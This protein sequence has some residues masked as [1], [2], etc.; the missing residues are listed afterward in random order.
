[1]H[2]ELVTKYL[3]PSTTTAKGHM[4]RV[5]NNIQLTHSDRPTVSE[6]QIAVNGRYS[7]DRTNVQRDQN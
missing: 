7:A 5:R 1:M 4:V 6:A 2:Q 3:E